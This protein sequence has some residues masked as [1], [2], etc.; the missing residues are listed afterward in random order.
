MQKDLKKLELDKILEKLADN[1][2]C[3]E[4]KKRALGL[5]LQTDLKS[6]SDSLNLTYEAFSLYKSFGAPSFHLPNELREILNLVSKGGI[7]S[8]SQLLSIAS[9]LRTYRYIKT[10]YSAHKSKINLLK[11]KFEYINFDEDLEKEIYSKI[12]SEEEI[13]D[14]ASKELFS[15]RK[16]INT[17]ERRIREKLEKV[18]KSEYYS[19]FLRESIVTIRDGRFVVPVKAENKSQI[20]GIEWDS[21]STGSTVFIEPMTV[22]DSNNKIRELQGKERIEIERI[23]A[24]LTEKIRLQE[25]EL[26]ISLE[27]SMFLEL[28]FAKAIFA[29]Q[30]K[31]TCPKVNDSGK[32]K[33]NQARHP[34]IDEKK[35]VPLDFELGYDFDTLVITGPNTGGKTV[36]LKTVGLLSAMTMCGLMIPAAENSE[37]SVFENIF[38]DIGDEQSIAQNLSTFS[39]HMKNIISI[40]ENCN[41]KSL[42]LIDEPGAGTDPVEGAALAIAIL[43]TLKL[44]GGKTVATTHYEKLK[45]YAISEQNVQNAACEFNIKT[46][47]PTYRLIIGMPGKSNAFEISKKLGLNSSV[48]ERA[49]NIVDDNNIQFENV[50]SDLE[51]IRLD[52]EEEKQKIEKDKKEAIKDREKAKTALEKANRVL[53]EEITRASEKAEKIVSRAT[54]EANRFLDKIK[55]YDNPSLNKQV[56][57]EINSTLKKLYENNNPV[58][59]NIDTDENYE[60]KRPY[61]EKDK[62]FIVSMQKKGEIISLEQKKNSALVLVG[63]MQLR[64]DLQDLRLLENEREDK[65]RNKPRKR[66]VKPSPKTQQVVTAEYD[67]RGKTVDEATHELEYFFDRQYR[68]G[69][70]TFAIIHGKGT[71]ALRKGIHEF[72]KKSDLVDS[73]RLGK[74][75]EGEDGVTI[76]TLK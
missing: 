48:I 10:Y 60:P 71:G 34:L 28:I 19:S 15:I 61:R 67:V 17:E 4:T 3:E 45:R 43:Q 26:K 21:S 31:A 39:S 64:V 68:I 30:M 41:D 56:K 47:S 53:N 16:A 65:N 37:I 74:Y 35:V 50:I 44:K 69:N 40:I 38:T 66:A 75:G 36:T 54:G 49:K 6:V 2:T 57:A 25:A 51:K 29:N 46:L 73:F 22:V 52:L 9:T 12:I 63:V 33:L 27:N 20:P 55:K 1:C 7:L 42:C 23:L 5:T 18:I 58:Y 70:M 32:I 76:V 13:A 59:E 14:D 72:L 11:D 8:F 62:V 24:N